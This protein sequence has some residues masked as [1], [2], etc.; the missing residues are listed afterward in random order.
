MAITVAALTEAPSRTTAISSRVR[1]LNST[2]G[3]SEAGGV[4]TERTAAPIRMASTMASIQPRPNSRSSRLCRANAARLTA[5][6]RARPGIREVPLRARIIRGDCAGE[7]RGAILAAVTGAPGGRQGGARH[8]KECVMKRSVLAVA[9]LVLAGCESEVDLPR[10]SAAAAESCTLPAGL[11]APRME[12]VEADE[13]VADRTILFHMLSVT[14]MPH[15]C[16]AG[17][18]GQG[19]LARNSDNRFGWT[20][21]GL[22]PAADGPP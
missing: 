6:H 8:D 18:D 21:H 19:D 22:W 13:V 16:R 2:P 12:R 15:T 11:P 7:A 1:A 9:L 14:W 4:H 20:L 10:T 3:R 17:G 5:A